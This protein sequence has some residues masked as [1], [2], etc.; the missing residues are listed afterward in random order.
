MIENLRRRMRHIIVPF[1]CFA[2]LI[3]C[4][5]NKKITGTWIL[6]N[7]FVN[8]DIIRFSNNHFVYISPYDGTKYSEECKLFYSEDSVTLSFQFGD[9]SFKFSINKDGLE[10]VNAEYDHFYFEQ[11]QDGNILDFFNRKYKR[12]INLPKIELDK[13]GRYPGSNNVFFINL[14][15][16][17]AK[18]FHN[19]MEYVIDSLFHLNLP[20]Q[21]E[22]SWDVNNICFFDAATPYYIVRKIK[23]E[24]AKISL[25]LRRIKYIS[26][27]EKNRLCEMN[28]RIPPLE[29][30]ITNQQYRFSLEV[31]EDKIIINSNNNISMEKLMDM[32]SAEIQTSSDFSF[33][34][35]I[36]NNVS[37]GHYIH[38]LSDIRQVYHTIRNEYAGKKYNVTDYRLLD[39]DDLY[40]IQEQIPMNYQ[41]RWEK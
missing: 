18:L 25:P 36:D 24:L 8:A 15:G 29:D 12:H 23:K 39:R 35:Y 7:D 4:T 21:E 9:N 5:N 37:Y 19:N 11:Y 6:Q 27:N 40:E 2:C 14:E 1:L 22:D 20:V 10:F 41:E 30:T 28:S 13:M 38:F 34:F 17:T 16:D 3:Q 33:E 26:V 31:Y 32:L